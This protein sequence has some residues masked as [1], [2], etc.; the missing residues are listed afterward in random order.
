MGKRIHT[1]EEHEYDDCSNHYESRIYQDGDKL[2]RVEFSNDHPYEKFNA[3][4]VGF[5]RDEY[6]EPIEVVEKE[7]TVV[8][9]YYEDKSGTD[10]QIQS[11]SVS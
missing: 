2:Y 7:R 11:S 8:E 3:D 6:Q 10:G 1:W 5:I 9:T 4:G